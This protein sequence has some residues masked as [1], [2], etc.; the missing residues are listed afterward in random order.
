MLVKVDKIQLY[1]Y[2]DNV[3]SFEFSYIIINIVFISIY[4]FCL[5]KLMTCI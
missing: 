3:S 2:L 1:I 5:K 4:L